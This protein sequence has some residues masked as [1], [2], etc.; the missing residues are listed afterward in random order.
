MRPFLLLMISLTKLNAKLD[1]PDPRIA[2]S[3]PN[4]LLAFGGD[5]S[6]KR[7]MLA[8]G[9][10]IFPWYSHDEPIMWWSPDPRGLLPL[11]NFYCSTKLAKLVRQQRYQITVNKAFEQVIDAC[12]TIPRNGSGTWITPQMIAAYKS[13]HHEGHAHSI[14]VWDEGMLVGGLYGVTS[15]KLFCGESMFHRV[16]DSSKLAMYYLVDLLRSEN[17]PI[18]D[19]QMQN[20]HLSSLGCIDVPRAQ[21]LQVLHKLQQ[22]NF[23]NN[24]WQARILRDS[25]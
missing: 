13:L 21:F 11:D 22:Q 14:E 3:E 8:Y 17:T 10:G 9:N 20:P 19:C 16:T 18:I 7:L 24:C 4:G 25:K 2:L 15:G 12:A 1:F 6:S 23:S 5:L